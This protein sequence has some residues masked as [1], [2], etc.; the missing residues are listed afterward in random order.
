[1]FKYTVIFLFLC[2]TS[3]VACQRQIDAPSN[4]F[5]ISTAT[6]ALGAPTFARTSE[7]SVEYVIDRMPLCS[8]IEK[9]D[10]P[11]VFDWPDIEEALEKLKEYNWGYYRCAL[12]QPALLAFHRQNMS[13]PPHLWREV[14]HAEHNGG[15]VVLYYQPFMVI[16]MYM[17]MLP[18]P[19][20]QT[21]YLVIARGDPGTPQTWEC[22]RTIPESR[23]RVHFDPGAFPCPAR[24]RKGG[25]S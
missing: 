10:A 4:A 2:L 21:S 13:K 8:G 11:L 25:S 18:N 24:I 3:S 14:N 12:S 22:R 17:W 5:A 19:D 9:L 6:P 16:W 15:I 7:S 23:V 20:K 1:M